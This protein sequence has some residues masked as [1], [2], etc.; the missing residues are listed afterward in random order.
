V[1][2]GASPERTA[3]QLIYF[4]SAS[5]NTARFVAKLDAQAARIPLYPS[6]APLKAT[7]EF[8]LV[9][10]TYGGEEGRRS[11]PPQVIR[12]LNDPDNRTLL[13]GVI[14]AGNTNF[15]TAYCLAGKKI[16]AKC[17]VPLMYKFELMG[18][19]EDVERVNKGLEQF[20]TARSNAA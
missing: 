9:V 16:A 11:I 18:T 19:P 17:D 20:W 12:F 6:D 15:G 5:N 8:V 1:T 10:P 4:S 2:D 3:A 14:A 7:R 13:R